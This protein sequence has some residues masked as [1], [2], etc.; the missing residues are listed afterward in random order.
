MSEVR[1]GTLARLAVLA[2]AA[3]AVPAAPAVAQVVV[4]PF[5][6]AY[7]PGNELFKEGGPADEGRQRPA[8]LGGI[9][10]TVSGSGILG[11]EGSLAYGPS[12]LRFK[13][14]GME[15]EVD[16]GLLFASLRA[17]LIVN[18]VWAPVNIYLAGGGALVHRTGPAY[19]GATD[20]STLGGTVGFGFLFRLS[21]AVRLRFE[22]EDVI[23]APSI[24][25]PGAEATGARTQH[26]FLLSAGVSV[27]VGF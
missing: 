22:A 23:T 10:I 20:V 19:E 21:P 25:F 13:T 1:A 18:S 5:V 12:D 7:V 8:P 24:T 11:L 14:A 17:V 26:D 15:S 2:A 3:A 16:G 9:R 4:T 6:G 27:P